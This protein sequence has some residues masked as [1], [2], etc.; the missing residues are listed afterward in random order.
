MNLP[1]PIK[2]WFTVLA[3]AVSLTV[4]PESNCQPAA[5]DA[6]FNPALNP[7]AQ[8]YAVALQTNGQVLIGGLFTAVAVGGATVTNIARLNPDGTLDATFNPGTAADFGYVSA[9]A[10]QK[11]GKVVIGGS[12]ASSTAAVPSNLARL[13]TNGTAD[14]SFNPNLWLD[15]AVNAAVVQEDGRILFGGAFQIVEGY[16]R[17]NIARLE[18]SG[19]V[20][21]GFDACVASS[22]GSGATA[23]VL[24]GDGKIL[25][26][27]GNFIFS[28]GAYRIGVARLNAN[29]DLDASYPPR[30]GLNANGIAYTMVGLS[31]GQALL[32]GSFTTYDVW[33]RNGIV[34]LTPEGNADL[35]FNPGTGINAAAIVYAVALQTGGKMLLGGSFTSFN[36]QTRNRLVRLNAN[37]SVDAS[38]DPGSGPNDSVGALAVQADGRILV[39]GKFS[40]F[41]GTPCHGLCR[42]QGDPLSRLGPPR[43]SANG[44]MELVFY[45][46]EQVHYSIEASTNLVNWTSMTDFTENTNVLVIADPEIRPG[47]F[48]RAVSLP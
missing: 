29:G 23:L 42:L 5:L 34:R 38:F 4:V 16:S 19:V 43:R 7:G 44:Q 24:L 22:S 33:S 13:N 10:V 3:L 21:T 37:G 36:G 25:M 20:D 31:D 1:M 2:P 39:A 47:R 27:G 6:G 28:A 46:R 11:D 26:S 41:N 40:A 9:I 48:Y 35:D 32:G 18:S 15:D 8:V 17:R 30:S 14:S 45:G 12:F